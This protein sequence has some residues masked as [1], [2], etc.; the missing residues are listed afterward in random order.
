VHQFV[1]FSVNTPVQL[2]YAAFLDHGVDFGEVTRFYQA[3]RD[4][5]LSL[6]EGSRFSPLRCHGTYFQILDYSGVSGGK[7]VDVAMDI[8]TRHGVAAIPT[9]AFLHASE[10][11]PVLRFCFAK[12]DD[13]LEAAADRLRRV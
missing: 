10:A 1:T 7:D 3:K 4:R 2:A 9:S 6:L 12:R 13:T 5:F 11:P 8:L